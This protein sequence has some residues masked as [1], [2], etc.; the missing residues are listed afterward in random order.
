LHLQSP[1]SVGQYGGKWCS[2]TA[3]PD[4]P[5]DQREDDGGS[6]I[7]DTDEFAE[8]TEIL[9]SAVVELELAA[10][11]P[12]AMVA[13]RLSDVAPDGSV[14]RISY[15]LLNLT[16][17]GSHAAPEP[18][19]PGERYVVPAQLNGAAQQI[20][21]GR[22]LLLAQR[23]SGADGDAALLP[24]GDPEGSEPIP[25][26]TIRPGEAQWTVT[27]DLVR[28]A[29]RLEVVKDEG[30]FRLEDIDLDVTRRAYERYS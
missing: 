2:Y 22:R 11:E 7:F 13:A 15:G 24:F 20:P 8:A 9:G 27:R 14:T 12:V 16:H 25:L 19:V 4:L 17:R 10:T 30:T 18:L 21:G 26:T 3:P 6:L 1:L 29:S 28:Y 23:I 5:Y